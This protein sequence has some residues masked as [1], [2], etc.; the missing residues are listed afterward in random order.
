[1]IDE[2]QK[3]PHLF[4]EIK[5][6]VDEAPRPGQ[7]LILG[8]T[9]FSIESK[10]K[11]SLTGRL[12]RLKIYP[13]NLSETQSL[14]MNPQ[15][16]FPFIGPKSRA[17]KQSLLKYLKNGGLPGI[18]IIKSELENQNAISDW[19]EPKVRERIEKLGFG[20]MKSVD[21]EAFDRLKKLPCSSYF[22]SPISS[23][24]VSNCPNRI[25]ELNEAFENAK[26]K[27]QVL[28]HSS[29]KR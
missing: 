29:K 13:F 19:I 28:D 14:P 22:L 21:P 10:I 16:Q 11:E 20:W 25:E 7:F 2:V 18:F 8:S 24:S 26:V 3:V 17:S 1:M 6:K 9:E 15:K 5:A 23:P 12:S 27:A 4:D